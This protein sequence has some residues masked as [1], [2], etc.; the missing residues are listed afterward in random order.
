MNTK[1]SKEEES[2]KAWRELAE[3]WLEVYEELHGE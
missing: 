3:A 1:N 2:R